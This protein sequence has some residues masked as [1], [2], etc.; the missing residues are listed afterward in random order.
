MWDLGTWFRGGLGS[1][2]EMSGL[3]QGGLFQSK[4]FYDSMWNFN[5]MR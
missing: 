2:R 3:E 4:L 5:T 1:V